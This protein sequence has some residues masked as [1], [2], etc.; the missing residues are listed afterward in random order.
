METAENENFVNEL[1]EISKYHILWYDG[2]D[3]TADNRPTCYIDG[4]GVGIALRKSVT[5]KNWKIDKIEFSILKAKNKLSLSHHSRYTLRAERLERG[6]SWAFFS[7][8][9]ETKD[10]NWHIDVIRFM[11]REDIRQA[12]NNF[13]VRYDEFL[14][15]LHKKHEERR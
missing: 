11:N 14:N 7:F 6:D 13:K 12:V 3:W 15:D 8:S 1:M 2:F 5:E 4:N 9:L 10:E